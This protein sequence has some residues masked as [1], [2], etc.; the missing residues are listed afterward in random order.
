MNCDKVKG[1]IIGH[2][3]GDA[4]GA[5]VEFYP[6][7]HFTGRLD[8]PIIRYTRAYGKQVS[9]IGQV[10]DD[11]EMAIVLLKTIMNGYTKEKAVENYMRWANNN[12]DNCK[13]KSPFMGKNTRNL[14]VA[15]KS[16]YALYKKRF[17]KYYPDNITME[18]SQSN[19]AL[20]RAYVHIF[21]QNDN[22]ILEDVF[23]TNPSKLVHNCVYVYIMAI[24]MA[25]MDTPKT[26][27]K[28]NIRKMIEFEELSVAYEQACSNKFRN[29]TCN[30][31][32]ILNAF[33]CAFW[34]LFN[35]EN[36]KDAIDSI[37]CLGPVDGEP[38]KICIKGSWKKSE[39]SVGDTD[40]N[41]AIA[42]ALLGAYYGYDKINED[43]VTK[44]NINVLLNCDS[45]RGD[46][47]RPKVYKM[48]K[49][50]IECVIKKYCV[51][52]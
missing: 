52:K 15:P 46:I 50:W 18:K 11:T 47:I 24:R 13:G 44:N 31:G 49:E 26:I 19:G 43:E 30:R 33:Y 40:T 12:Y 16:T 45:S 1:I 2:A 42:G 27:I 8:T 4:L 48:E 9:D 17:C 22:I 41:A 34:G 10:S 29:V 36:Y 37:I 35:F 20:M 38:A 28:D 39:I 6:Y 51:K 14:F 32:H 21:T 7:A 3:L 5:P 25:I 23:I